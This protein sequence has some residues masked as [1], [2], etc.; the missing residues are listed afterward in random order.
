MLTQHPSGRS[1]AY[2]APYYIP[3]VPAGDW[4]GPPVRGSRYPIPRKRHL[5]TLSYQEGGK[6]RR[7]QRSGNKRLWVIISPSLSSVSGIS[8]YRR[9][10]RDEDHRDFITFIQLI[11]E[12]N[13]RDAVNLVLLYSTTFCVQFYSIRNFVF[14]YILKTRIFS[15]F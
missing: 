10:T 6:E 13:N 11:T 15:S 3:T 12:L 14:R 8:W 2:K 1:Q 5:P 9:G 7:D 4:S